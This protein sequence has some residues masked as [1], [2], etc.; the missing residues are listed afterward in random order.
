MIPIT[1]SFFAWQRGKIKV[2]RLTATQNRDHDKLSFL[3]RN[4]IEVM[5]ED[6]PDY[7]NEPIPSSILS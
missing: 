2:T 7:C 6:A 1:Y 3:N 5:E 4:L